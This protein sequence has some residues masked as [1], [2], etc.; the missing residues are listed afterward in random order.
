M[1][2]TLLSYPVRKAMALELSNTLSL[3]STIEPWITYIDNTHIHT[4]YCMLS[5]CDRL[6]HIQVV[7]CKHFRVL[8]TCSK[9][10]KAYLFSCNSYMCQNT[11]MLKWHTHTVC[12]SLYLPQ[13]HRR[14]CSSWGQFAWTETQRA[15]SLP[16][17]VLEMQSMSARQRWFRGETEDVSKDKSCKRTIRREL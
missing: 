15:L 7:I 14:S 17:P 4:L 12:D 9:I 8:S 13:S 2:Y 16:D 1:H 6:A 5:V 11:H 3:S 10:K